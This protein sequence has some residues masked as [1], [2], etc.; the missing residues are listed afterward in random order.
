[1]CIAFAFRIGWSWSQCHDA[2]EIKDLMFER[3][4]N[5]ISMMFFFS[6][7]SVVVYAWIVTFDKDRRRRTKIMFLVWNI[8]LYIFVLSVCI[9]IPDEDKYGLVYQL[10]MVVIALSFLVL[11]L[12]ILFV[13][14]TMKA[15]LQ[16]LAQSQIVRDNVS[17]LNLIMSICTICFLVRFIMFCVSPFYY[18]ELKNMP[19]IDAVLY[20]WFFYPVPE[21][22]PG[23]VVLYF[24]GSSG[25]G[26]LKART[27]GN[28]RQSF[29]N[30]RGAL[31]AAV[32]YQ[33][34]VSGD[35]SDDYVAF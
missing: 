2:A 33:R 13:G 34:Q 14:C 3:V 19:T 11:G 15:R 18:V 7:F 10:S 5:R 24:T 6:A 31:G 16:D 20:P 1:M 22:I 35:I 25:G 27:Y 26:Y 28:T 12:I 29:S 23:L 32:R 21:I 9:F 4:V 30:A 8:C 17:R